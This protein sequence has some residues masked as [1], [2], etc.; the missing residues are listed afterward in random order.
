MAMTNVRWRRSGGAPAVVLPKSEIGDGK[1][2]GPGFETIERGGQVVVTM[3]SIMLLLRRPVAWAGCRVRKGKFAVDALSA[4]R[5]S[6]KR[7]DRCPR[8]SR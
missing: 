6:G 1:K 8:T 7:V 5:R 2:V 4:P 3:I